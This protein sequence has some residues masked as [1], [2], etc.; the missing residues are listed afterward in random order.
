MKNTF[1]KIIAVLSVFFTLNFISSCISDICPPPIYFYLKDVNVQALDRV[2]DG[3]G[4]YNAVYTD[5]IRHQIA[6][7]VR[8]VVELAMDS[9]NR[10]NWNLMNTAYGDCFEGSLA[11]NPIVAE[12]S[13]M[14]VDK[15]IYWRGGTIEPNTNILENP[16]FKE[17]VDFPEVLTYE[18]FEQI[19]IA[20]IPLKFHRD[21]YVFT[22]EWETSD[23]IILR[24]E[25]EVVIRLQ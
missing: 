21:P 12:K 8:S 9:P 15:P 2:E 24:D 1:T 11:L 20:D 14:F 3:V 25:A 4:L 5:T 6:F 17:Y 23:G 22:F 10:L 18:G 13:R 16:E 7:E 19:K